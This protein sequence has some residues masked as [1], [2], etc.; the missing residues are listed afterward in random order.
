MTKDEIQ[1]L[2]RE[3]GR[4]GAQ[5]ALMALGIDMQDARQVKDAR[6]AIAWAG[7]ARKGTSAL[8]KSAL[9][10]LVGLLITGIAYA[11]WRALPG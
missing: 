7:Q 5:Q 6:G 8:Q 10:T 1:Q 2:A 11:V 9:R 4:E 3:A